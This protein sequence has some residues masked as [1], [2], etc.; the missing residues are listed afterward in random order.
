MGRLI[1]AIGACRFSIHA[2]EKP[3]GEL[4]LAL[5]GMPIPV[6]GCPNVYHTGKPL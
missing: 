2:R 4:Q 5:Q 1:R 6:E 3:E